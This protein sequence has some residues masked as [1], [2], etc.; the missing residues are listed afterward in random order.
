M[1]DKQTICQDK[2]LIDLKKSIG[3]PIL[4]AL[5]PLIESTLAARALNDIYSRACLMDSGTNFFDR[6]LCTAGVNY[7]ISAEDR[8]RIPKD[9]TLIVVSNHPYGGIDG[10]A[11]GS[12]LCSVRE[13][14]KFL[15]NYMLGAIEELKPYFISVDPFGGANATRANIAPI[16]EALKWLKNGGCLG[17]FPSGTVSHLQLK[18]RHVSDPEW[19]DN[20]AGLIRRTGASV[21]PVF[22][23]GRNSN[24]F[25]AA[26]LLHPRL[27]TALLVRELARMRGQTIEI[28][29]GQPIPASR[30]VKFESDKEMT[31][32]MRLKTY[33]LRNRNEDVKKRRFIKMP[34]RSPKAKAPMETIVPAVDPG[35]LAAE[36]ATLPPENT[37]VSHGDM[38]VIMAE[39]AQIPNILR[40]IGRLREIT[41]RKV[42]EGTG[43]A[44]DLDQY[45]AYYLHLFLWN[46]AAKE[47][48]GGYRL[49]RT[50][51]ILAE[52]GRKGIYTTSL[53]RF[54]GE[55]L[56]RISP[57]LEM[58]R[59]FIREEYQ[60]KPT[61]LP[62]I[63]RGI[64]EYICRN[65]AYRVLFGPV[66][67]SSD[68]KR[69]SRDLMVQ[70]LRNNSLDQEL[71]PLVKARRPPNRGKFGQIDKKSLRATIKDVE[72]ISALVSDIETDRKGVP[73]LL[74]HYLKLN[75]TILSFNVDKDFCDVIDGLIVVDLMRTDP[76]IM[77]RFM[78][79]EGAE[80]FLKLHGES[81]E[82]AVE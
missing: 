55:L 74:K 37:L 34:M 46:N 4:R 22:I 18:K 52:Q 21:L 80:K 16:K 49:G 25:Q 78:S 3:N 35:I 6:T 48:V 47:I 38:S 1:T 50:D 24:F 71:H 64:G 68:Y 32:F 57:A 81:V 10:M 72:D 26:G 5:A 66:S 73:V 76:K 19:N 8:D 23:Q 67:I 59:S 70:Y 77:K 2:K 9:G 79:D 14:T 51:R 28:R 43:K 11:L 61:A 31:S 45:D 63:W 56:E 54:K 30:L 20:V 44:L 69:A 17:T 42:G 27:R 53:F 33:N 12:L 29:I 40:E 39:S 36:I 82:K 65:P 13:D 75:A 62:L 7:V 41:F 58:G 15:V 60:R